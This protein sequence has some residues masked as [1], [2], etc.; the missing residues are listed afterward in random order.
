MTQTY[1]SLLI[2]LSLN[3]HAFTQPVLDTAALH[4]HSPLETQVLSAQSLEPPNEMK[5]RIRF[6]MAPD[7]LANEESV[8][9]AANHVTRII[10]QLE[11]SSLQRKKAER[12]AKILFNSVHD[13]L[14]LK[15]DENAAFNQ[16]FND[17][18][19]NCVTATALYSLIL[20]YF[21]IAYQIRELPSH[22]YLILHPGPEQ[23]ILEST[24][25]SLGVFQINKS[26]AVRM[27]V[28]QKII[29]E[30][31]FRKKSIDELYSEYLEAEERNINLTAILS[32]TIISRKIWPKQPLW[33]I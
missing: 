10:Q 17:G 1:Y 11:N 6:L 28:E 21:D 4:F 2:C 15:Y 32:I 13:G 27:L 7:S 18:T 23:L 22:V 33:L 31:E 8:R 12:A 29:S 5:A 30:A 14:L 16:I 9:N 26:K 19:Y 20:D 25:P 3:F 24:D